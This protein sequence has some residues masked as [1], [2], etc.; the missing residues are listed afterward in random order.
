ML[1]PHGKA[2]TNTSR[3]SGRRICGHRPYH[4]YHLQHRLEC[5]LNKSAKR[6]GKV[7]VQRVSTTDWQSVPGELL[8]ACV[9]VT[10]CIMAIAGS[11]DWKIF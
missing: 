11:V 1:V 8:V 3:V 9:I 7:A 5:H 10:G 2:G 6:K 4:S